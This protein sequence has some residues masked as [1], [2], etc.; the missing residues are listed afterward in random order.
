MYHILNKKLLLNALE[1][2]IFVKMKKGTFFSNIR[3]RGTLY[4]NCLSLF[5]LIAN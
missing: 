2:N 3:Q 5:T 1:R 4:M